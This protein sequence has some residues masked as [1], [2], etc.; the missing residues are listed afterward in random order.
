MAKKPPKDMEVGCIHP[1]NNYGD[2]VIVEY[3]NGENVVVQFKDTGNER[4]A[5]AGDIRKGR[6]ADKKRAKPDKNI[7]RLTSTHTTA[8]GNVKVVEYNNANNIKI[9]FEATGSVL[10]TTWQNLLNAN[11]RDPKGERGGGGK[12]TTMENDVANMQA[13]LEA[14][15]EALYQQKLK[16]LKSNIDEALVYLSI[17]TV[18]WN[19]GITE[20]D[21]KIYFKKAAQKNHPDKHGGDDREYRLV[22]AAWEKIKYTIK[23][24]NAWK[25][26]QDMQASSRRGRG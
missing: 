8:F 9:R 12:L 10:S 7:S 16:L 19:S 18:D 11:V 1:T 3:Q 15:K 23:Y 26:V 2:L 22:Q 17:P 13:E 25:S 4:V 5:A 21:L 24:A 6:V 14:A 20:K